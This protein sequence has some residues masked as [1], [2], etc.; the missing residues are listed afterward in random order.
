MEYT[1]LKNG[2]IVAMIGFDNEKRIIIVDRI[3]QSISGDYKL[4][5]YAELDINTNFGE[6]ELFLEKYEPGYS[7]NVKDWTFESVEEEDKIKLYHALGKEFTEEYDSDWYEHF[8][9]SSYYDIQDFLFDVF[10]IKVEEYDNDLIYPVFVDDIQKYIWCKCC[11][12]VGMSDGFNEEPKEKMVSVDKIREWLEDN[13]F[14]L[15]DVEND[16][17]YIQSN[18]DTFDRLIDSFNKIINE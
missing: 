6:V 10:C 15:Q 3:E 14:E 4:Y 16:E 12:A 13:F 9:D 8:T 18:F 1:D 7:Y 5:T 17:C 2:D 11:E